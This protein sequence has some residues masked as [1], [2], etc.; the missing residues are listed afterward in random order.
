MPRKIHALFEIIWKTRNEQRFAQIFGFRNADFS[1]VKRRAFPPFR[2]KHLVARR[3]EG[4]AD[5]D[6]AVV[7]ERESYAKTR[8]TVREIRR[9]V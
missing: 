6:F 9:A 4:N 2:R 8:I 3:V 1:I 7:F 5:D